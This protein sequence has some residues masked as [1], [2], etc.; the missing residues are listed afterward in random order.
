VFVSELREQITAL[1]DDGLSLNEIAH[2]LALARSTVGYHARAVREQPSETAR[3]PRVRDRSR[4]AA[5]PSV[6]RARVRRLL[7]QGLSRAQVAQRL[8]LARSTVTYHAD[9]LGEGVDPRFA[10][11][12]DW[13]AIREFYERGHSF[14]ECRRRF[15]FTKQAWHDAIRRGLVTPRPARLPIDQLLVAGPRRGRE[16]L[17]RRLYD[18]G[19]KPRWCERCG[20]S[21]WRGAPLALE[22]HHVN[23]DRHDNRLENLLILCP[24]CH[25]QTD[26]WAGRKRRDRA[27][28]ARADEAPQA[29]RARR[30]PL[31][32]K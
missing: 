19:L 12:Y 22:L 26:T 4:P 5:T 20:L 14:A 21:Q 6:T 1:L 17:K 29:S 23:G 11:R 2:R 28:P 30:V 18:A 27:A 9:R 32:S 25:S 7:A 8:H 15:G 13:P 10:R 16:H 3:P 31:G 24:N